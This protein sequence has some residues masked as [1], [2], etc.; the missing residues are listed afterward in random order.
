MRSTHWIR[1]ARWNA[2][3]A[4]IVFA[5][6]AFGGVEITGFIDYRYDDAENAEGSFQFRPGNGAELDIASVFSP[7][8]AAQVT[9][10]SGGGGF[11]LGPTFL[12]MNLKDDGQHKVH[13]EMVDHSGVKIGLF[14]VPF[15]I[16]SRYYSSVD[17]PTVS[18]P[19]LTARLF[20]GGW[21]DFGFD[22]YL[23]NECG[24]EGCP[25][26]FTLDIFGVT[27][28]QWNDG[29][30]GVFGNSDDGLVT[31]PLVAFSNDRT[32][33]ARLG[34][35][36]L[37]N[38]D[39]GGSFATG[40]YHA[41]VSGADPR[42]TLAGSTR[43]SRSD[44][45]PCA[46]STRT[47]RALC[48]ELRRDRCARGMSRASGRRRRRSIRLCGTMSSTSTTTATAT[49]CRTTARWRGCLARSTR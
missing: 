16:E 4:V 37:P 3:I 33:G 13:G 2:C 19:F 31:V 46:A 9:L 1:R 41:N 32:F 24:R 5:S 38:L 30:D 44:R 34:Y 42:M 15:G 39:L 6:P 47:S 40:S 43:R 12:D 36:V 8:L 48:P 11:G 14:D 45:S 25:G 28:L 18:A 35:S 21:T 26:P 22:L 49:A 23:A 17:R 29:A 10:V 7:R 20:N 27:G